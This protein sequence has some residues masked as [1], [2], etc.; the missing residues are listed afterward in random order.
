MR[1]QHGKVRTFQLSDQ[2]GIEAIF[3]QDIG[4]AFRRHIHRTFIFGLVEQGS[5]KI[6]CSGQSFSVER[7]EVFILN[8]GQ[9]HACE[10]SPDH[11]YRVLSIAPQYMHALL[12]EETRYKEH[13]THFPNVAYGNG[14]IAEKMHSIFASISGEGVQEIALQKTFEFLQYTIRRHAKP[15]RLTNQNKALGAPTKTACRYLQE[16]FA[17]KVSLANLAQEALLS[18]F[19]LQ[20]VFMEQIGVTPHEYLQAYRV[21]EARKRLITSEETADLAVQLGFCDQSHFS[22]V[23]RK[24]MGVSP[25]RYGNGTPRK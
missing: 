14:R 4:N 11:C 16:H 7:N 25:R 6:I 3:G 8:P 20:R 21:A 23:F 1:K 9:I 5:R 17:E 2:L 18:P 15:Q 22:R 12:L 19:H 10:C 24:I 13:K